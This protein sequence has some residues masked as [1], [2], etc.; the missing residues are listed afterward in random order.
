MAMTGRTAMSSLSRYVVV[1]GFMR[2]G[3]GVWGHMEAF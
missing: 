2:V 3:E 1:I